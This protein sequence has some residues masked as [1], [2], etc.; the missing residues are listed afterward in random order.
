MTDQKKLDKL[1]WFHFVLPLL[2]FSIKIYTIVFHHRFEFDTDE[3]INLIKA[4]L[5]RDGFQ[6]Y[7]DIWSDQPPFL[8]HVLAI[9]FD[10]LGTSVSLGRTV[11]LVFATLLLWLTWLVLYLLGGVSH[12]YL[13]SLFLLAAPHYWRLSISVM[14]G[15]PC[16]ALALGSIVSTILW[17]SNQKKIWLFASA[18]LLSMSVFTKLITLF[19]APIIVV[20]IIALPKSDRPSWQQRLRYPALWVAIFVLFSLGLM[21]WQTGTSNLDQ[22]FTGHASARELDYYREITLSTAVS[23]IYSCCL[24]GFTIWGTI[25]AVKKAQ[26]S[27]LYF[28]A[29][30]VA[31]LLLL[32][33][34]RPVWYHQTL[35][36]SVPG[37]VMVGYTLGEFFRYRKKPFNL[38]SFF[39]QKAVLFAT[40]AILCGAIIIF[41]QQLKMK[42]VGIQN[43]LVN[44]QN[45]LFNTNEYQLL[46]EIEQFKPQTDWIVTDL[47]MFAFRAGIPVPPPLAVVSNKQLQTGKITDKVMLDVIQTYQPRQI[48]FGR[49]EWSELTES[50]QENYRLHKQIEDLRLYLR[51]ERDRI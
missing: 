27:M 42:L 21:L 30:S 46:Q 50:I 39:K 36:F 37:T 12:A 7:Q 51:L 4:L 11:I 29:W 3:G 34:H 17:H 44:S 14:I 15:L 35:L 6:L 1:P 19:L 9:S 13:G 31:A 5:V 24:L 40:L 16:I 45:E 2:F 38:Y 10:L 41:G 26:W 28:A 8:T 23:N 32:I 47:P 22:L 18:A 33:D 43:W 48:L 20:G 25:L 49:F